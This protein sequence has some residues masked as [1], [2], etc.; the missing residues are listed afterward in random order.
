MLLLQSLGPRVGLGAPPLPAR[1]SHAGFLVAERTAPQAAHLFNT[2]RCSSADYG[3]G[4]SHVI[5]MPAGGHLPPR[6]SL[7]ALLRAQVLWWLR[8]LQGCPALLPF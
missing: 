7:T 4:S 1:P 8:S 3:A 6:T 5:N 2:L